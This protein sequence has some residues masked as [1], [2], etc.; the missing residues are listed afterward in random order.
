MQQRFKVIW[1]RGVEVRYTKD[2]LGRSVQEFEADVPEG[3]VVGSVSQKAGEP[4]HIVSFQ[5]PE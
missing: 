4:G 1:V 3:A 2:E 5:V